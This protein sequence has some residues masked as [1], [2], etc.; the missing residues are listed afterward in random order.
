MVPA[1]WTK[2]TT[3]AMTNTAA[4]FTNNDDFHSFSRA[5][6]FVRSACL[7]LYT[8]CFCWPH[9]VLVYFFVASEGTLKWRGSRCL[10]VH[11]FVPKMTQCAFRTEISGVFPYEIFSSSAERQLSP[12]RNWNVLVFP[13]FDYV[14]QWVSFLC[15]ILLFIVVNKPFKAVSHRRVSMCLYIDR[16]W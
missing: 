14:F 1:S 15:L 6:V 8:F 2:T 4:G 3:K 12:R 16:P 11:K 10:F 5:F 13:L 9:V 7:L